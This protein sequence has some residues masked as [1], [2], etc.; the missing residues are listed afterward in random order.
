M[1]FGRSKDIK[2]NEIF[3][4]DLP[5]PPQD[6]ADELS[7][8]IVSVVDNESSRRW[9]SEFHR[10]QLPVAYMEYGN[11][12]TQSLLVKVREALLEIYQPYFKSPIE[13]VIAKIKNASSCPSVSPPH[14]DRGRTVAINYL[15]QAGG[16]A[17][18]TCFYHE[19]RIGS[20]LSQ[21][22]NIFYQDVNLAFKVIFPIKTWHIFDPQR[23]HSVE[24]IKD[25]RFIFSIYLPDNP[26]FGEF[27]LIYS[28][29]LIKNNL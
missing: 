11:N 23:A 25:E 14:C 16:D 18:A 17:V 1:P 9:L 22:E 2:D 7:D 10:N 6:L 26:N 27:K 8:I 13:I 5:H 12:N 19:Y 21:S 24:N 15:L 3:F 4:L 29:L 28:N 20:D